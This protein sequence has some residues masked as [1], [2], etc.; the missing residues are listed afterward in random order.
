MSAPSYHLLF[1]DDA[2]RPSQQFFSHVG[3]FLGKTSSKQST[4]CLHFHQEF[5]IIIYLCISVVVCLLVSFVL[6]LCL[7]EPFIFL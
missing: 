6:C 1:R 3:H 5:F 2:L 7:F 4:K